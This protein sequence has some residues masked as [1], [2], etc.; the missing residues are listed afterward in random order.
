MK[1]KIYKI[2]LI[3]IFSLTFNSC[4]N[5]D[6]TNESQSLSGNYSGTFTVEYLNGDTFSNSVSVNFGENNN[7]ES[8]GNGN[9]ND[10]YPAGG[11]GSYEINN[12]EITFSDSNIWLANFDWNLILAG[13]YEY[14]KNGN[15]L[16]IST[17]KT[18][19]GIYKY[20]LTKE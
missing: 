13:E 11:K 10:F 18:E 14:S 8:S 2:S 4:S 17:N 9:N 1:Y 12:S 3:A 15:E 7:Y 5:D 19:L 20:E 16:I 6:N